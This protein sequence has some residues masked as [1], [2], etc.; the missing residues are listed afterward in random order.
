MYSKQC[1]CSAL[2]CTA[3]DSAGA[4]HQAVQVQCTR[5]CRLTAPGSAGAVHQTVLVLGTRQCS[6]P[7]SAGAR[8]QTVQVLGTRQ[9]RFSAPVSAGAVHQSVQVQ[10]TSQCRCSAAVSAGADMLQCTAARLQYA[11]LP[12]LPHGVRGRRAAGSGWDANACAGVYTRSAA[13]MKFANA[14]LAALQINYNDDDDEDGPQADPNLEQGMPLPNRL[15]NQFPSEMVGVPL[16]D[17]DPFY[18]NKRGRNSFIFTPILTVFIDSQFAVL[19]AKF[20]ALPTEIEQKKN[21]GRFVRKPERCVVLSPPVTWYL[22]FTQ[23]LFII[24]AYD[25]SSEY[26]SMLL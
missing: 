21:L 16:E 17:I 1:Y 15:A 4:V 11:P 18:Y 14:L 8:H 24:Q 19:A 7:D 26:Y 12:P 20:G 22:D 23:W 25:W 6:A 9:C 5:Q 10:C 3:P 2:D 13:I